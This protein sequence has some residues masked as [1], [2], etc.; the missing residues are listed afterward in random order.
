MYELL[1][2]FFMVFIQSVVGVFILLLIGG[3]MGLVVLWCKVIGL[4]LVMC[5]FGFG[6][7]VGI[8]YVG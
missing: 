1:L 2:V 4:F 6:V 7:I 5:L 3:V 8:F